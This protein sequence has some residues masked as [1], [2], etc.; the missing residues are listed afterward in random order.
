MQAE[1]RRKIEADRFDPQDLL[2]QAF[3]VHGEDGTDQ[4]GLDVDADYS[5][6]VVEEI[7][8]GRVVFEVSA[9]PRLDQ[10]G[11]LFF[12]GDPAVF[13]QDLQSAQATINQARLDDEITGPER[14]VRAG[15]V[16]A[17]RGLPDPPADM[18][19]PDA[20]WDISIGDAQSISDISL[21][22]RNAAKAAL[23]GAAASTVEEEYAR[24]MVI[25]AEYEEEQ[26][27]PEAGQFD[28]RQQSVTGGYDGLG[29]DEEGA[30]R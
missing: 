22:G 5:Y 8:D 23:Y 4:Q 28:V 17:V 20:V 7:E 29:W 11:R 3:T 9:W 12:E 1:Q 6:V 2:W 24:E 21:A 15:D 30:A 19:A 14:P 13:F 10:D 16:F 25:S 18:D 27:A 26:T